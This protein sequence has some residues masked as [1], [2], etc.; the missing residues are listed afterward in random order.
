[1]GSRARASPTVHTS[2]TPAI[3]TSSDRMTIATVATTPAP[4]ADAAVPRTS[5]HQARVHTAAVTMSTGPATSAEK[6]TGLIATSHAAISPSRADPKLRPSQY[7]STMRAVLAAAAII[8]PR[9]S[10]HAIGPAA[11]ATSSSL[12]SRRVSAART[13]VH[14]RANP[15][16]AVT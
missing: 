1:S 13:D 8:V 9:A 14:D 2:I 11:N 7:V 10:A 16:A 3:G 12:S 15:C 6:S 4:T 5:R